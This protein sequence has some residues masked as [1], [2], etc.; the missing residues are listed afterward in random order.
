VNRVRKLSG[1]RKVGHTGTLDPM[2]TGVLLLCLGQATRLIEYLMGRCKQYQATIRF[3]LTTDTLDAEGK[4]IRQTDPSTLTEARLREILPNFLG[5]IQQVPPIFSALKKDG[6]PLYKLARAG[7]AVETAPRPVTI[8]ALTW[9]AWQPPDLTLEISCSAGTYIRALARDLGEAAATGACLIELTRTANGAWSLDQ[10]VSLETLEA[11]AQTTPAGWRKYL[12][13]FDQAVSH[14]AKIT[15]DEE[16]A[17]HV[18]HGRQIKITPSAI[19]PTESFS[20]E[21]Q[22]IRAYTPDGE[23]LAI[24][25]LVNAAEN[26][27]Q[28]K[29]VFNQE[30]AALL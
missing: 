20:N 9:R 11:A 27:W 17:G 24:L 5:E 1:Q 14:L 16:A 26:I 18:K 2:A 23:F 15:L 12:Y 7:T 3:G 6:Q 29:K 8:Y 4:I 21:L 25:T 19:I 22:F 10:A 30:T 13:P 28:P